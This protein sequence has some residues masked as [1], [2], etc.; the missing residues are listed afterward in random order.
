[1]SIWDF[2]TTLS[3]R[4]LTWAGVSAALGLIMQFFGRFWRSVGSQ[5]IGWGAVNAAIAAGG[6]FAAQQRRA[7][8]ADSG[9]VKRHI[10]EADSLR[11]LLWLN[12]WLDVLYMIFGGWLL[13][14][15][16]KKPGMRGAGLG[17]LL[18]GLALFAFDL[19][20]TARL[21]MWPWRG[22]DPRG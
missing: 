1:M 16:G 14:R 6:D 2:Q 7:K 15:R 19:I 12:T 4:L 17:I 20:H 3:R 5:F 18:Q 22:S 13:T 11:R 8:L 9:T 10:I 21:P